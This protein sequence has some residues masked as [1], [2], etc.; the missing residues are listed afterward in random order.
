MAFGKIYGLVDNPRTF[1]CLMVAKANNLD[2]E[3]VESVPGQVDKAIH[4]LGKVPAF[5][6]ANGFALT[7]CI[8]I[9]VYL[10]SQN[11]KTT[12][13]GKTKQDY[14]SILRWMSFTNQDVLSAIAGWFRPLLGRDAYNK[15]AVEE[16]SKR[17]LAAMDVL[18]AH[19]T[20]NTF[21]VGERFTLA[22]LFAAAIVSRGMAFVL[23]R[24]WRLAHPA[25][26]RWFETV[27]NQP[28]YKAVVP[29]TVFC[30]EALKNVPPKKEE[31]AKPT[32][33]PKK[34]AAEA[35]EEEEKPAPKPPKHPL[36]SLPKPSMILDDWKRKYSNEDS[37]TV[38][39]PWFWEHYNPEEYSLWRVEYKYNDELKLTFM[40]NNLIGGFFARL[41]ASRKYLFGTL[42]VYGENN[43]N[44]IRGAFL[45]R[46]TEH[47]PAFDVAPDWESYN[48]TKLDPS[49]PEDKKY[50]EDEWAQ[51]TNAV[52]DGKEY[53][54]AQGK[55]FK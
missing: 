24:E 1:V 12:L 51:D 8:A 42:T 15:K 31:K 16:S 9:A 28:I 6:G 35:E 47:E 53:V 49:K 18:E 55:V 43:N 44:F 13:L 40:S 33:A 2:L 46:G 29:E 14:A 32:P 26:T 19:L 10:A 36:E 38:A 54:W 39:F 52:I 48:F 41:E 25:V 22:D 50:I 20:A 30:E 3:L 17:A 7:E 27:I 37:R 5:V 23:D 45:A 21:L 34:A 11:E 4:P